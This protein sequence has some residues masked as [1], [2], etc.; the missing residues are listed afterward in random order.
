MKGAHMHSFAYLFTDYCQHWAPLAPFALDAGSCCCR[1]V[2]QGLATVV[3]HTL[4]NP[5]GELAAYPS[6][7]N[8]SAP[9]SGPGP[10]NMG[11]AGM[12]M[13]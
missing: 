4:V 3:V 2:S 12:S 6:S 13:P 7:M 5:G 11:M 8:S 9:M 10:M 1:Y